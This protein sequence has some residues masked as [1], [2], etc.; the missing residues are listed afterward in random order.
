MLDFVLWFHR[1]LRFC[2]FYFQS[3]FSLVF[4]LGYFCS[5]SSS[6]YFLPS[7]SSVVLLS[8]ATEPFISVIVFFHPKISLW[9]LLSSV[10]FSPSLS[11]WLH[12]FP[13]HW[14]FIF[15][16]DL[17]QVF[18]FVE[19]YFIFYH[20]CFKNLFQKILLLP[21]FSVFALADYQV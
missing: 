17:F 6:P 8:L 13:P 12:L 18:V 5:V 15:S 19:T 16:F 21:S 9:F 14:G 4:R 7:L 10:S 11:A 1:S 2:S 20:D 3:V